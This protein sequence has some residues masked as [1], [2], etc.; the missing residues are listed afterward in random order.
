MDHVSTLFGNRQQAAKPRHHTERGDIFD[1]ILSHLNPPRAKKGM[2]PISYER[3]G[4]LLTAIPTKDL[5]SLISKCHDAQRR[6]FPWSAIFWKEIT[7]QH[8][9]P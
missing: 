3:L 8:Q 1:T 6:G 9:D 7:P 5:Y 2:P 4:Y